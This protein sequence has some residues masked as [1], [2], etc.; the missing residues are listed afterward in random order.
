MI[1]RQFFKSF[2]AELFHHKLTTKIGLIG[3]FLIKFKIIFIFSII[4]VR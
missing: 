4:V 1:T 3:Y 2:K